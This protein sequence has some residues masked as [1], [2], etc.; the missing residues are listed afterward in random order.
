MDAEIQFFMT[1]QDESDFFA[2]VKK[3]VDTMKDVE[4]GYQLVIGDCELYFVPS[5]KEGNILYTGKLEIRLGNADIA[6][7]DL[8]RAKSTFRK[9]RNWV[10][11]NYWSRLAYQNK[12]KKN[13]LTP[14]RVH[15]LGPDAK[16]W[17]E[18]S[19]ENHV[20]KL[21]KTSWMVFELGY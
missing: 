11:K 6:Y 14:S 8:E 9:L 1:K 18:A 13:K 5:E 7:Q 15:W 20:L 21:S 2:F 19:P 10:K 12:N 4:S 17:K 3:Q 16:K